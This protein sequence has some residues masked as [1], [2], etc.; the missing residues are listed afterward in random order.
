MLFNEDFYASLGQPTALEARWKN[1]IA[2]ILKD[3]GKGHHYPKYAEVF[4][5]FT[6]RI[7]PKRV[8]PTFTAACDFDKYTILVSE[9]LLEDP[10]MLFQLSMLIRHEMAH[11]LMQHSIRWAALFSDDVAKSLVT[12]STVHDIANILSDDEISNTR[13]SSFDKD[14]VRHLWIGG[15]MISGL[16]TEDHRPDWTKL[17]LE[18]MYDEVVDELKDLQTR[19]TSIMQGTTSID[20][21]KKFAEGTKDEINHS[22]LSALKSYLNP[23]TKSSFSAGSL[24]SFIQG[25]AIINGVSLAKSSDEPE[26]T[27]FKILDTLN[28]AYKALITAGRS[29]SEI[30]Q[31][32]K[33]LIQ[34]ITNSAVFDKPV[35]LDLNS[36]NTIEVSS[37][38]EKSLALDALKSLMSE[39]DFNIYRCLTAISRIIKTITLNKSIAST[40]I[41]DSTDLTN[42]IKKSIDTIQSLLDSNH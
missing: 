36:T 3:D 7:V 39:D 14:V 31:K 27:Y 9:G 30:N 19:L 37:P 2:Q 40:A 13:Y 24:D 38:E 33:S 25:G 42:S 11:A 6:L 20:D 26:A 16:V 5:D 10:T 41:S 23:T 32:I 35:I 15:N 1:K 12:S 22:L 21:V 18:D 8:S 17:S 29:S 28:T 4:L 34:K